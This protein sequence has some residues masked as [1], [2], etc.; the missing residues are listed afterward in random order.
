MTRSDFF[1]L[2]ISGDA[3]QRGQQYGEQACELIH[4]TFEIYA[5]LLA[6]R[7]TALQPLAE[8]YGR[9]IAAFSP[10]LYAEIDAIA[11]A[12]G[13]APWQIVALNA[14]TEI[15]NI[16]APECTLLALPGQRRLAQ[17]WDWIRPLESR[18]IELTVVY[19]DGL[20]IVMLLEP[21]QIGKIGMNNAGLGVGLNILFCPLTTPGLPVHVLMRSMLECQSAAEAKTV[22]ETAPPGRASHLCA[23]D[24]HGDFWTMEFVDTRQQLVRLDEPP[25]AHSNHYRLFPNTL[26]GPAR[27]NS[28]LRQQRAE[29][30]LSAQCEAEA[31]L[32]DQNNGCDAIFAPYHDMPP[33]GECGTLFSV[34]MDLDQPE[35]RYRCRQQADTDWNRRTLEPYQ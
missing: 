23:G 18:V 19:P 14:R 2:R 8:T 33:V 26:E 11:A 13:L 21:G 16:E 20:E 29:Q 31:I 12:S 1:R 34:I 28:L 24:R 10:P 35:L 25:F 7:G 3:R 4:E 30:L 9:C 32:A 17:N 5:D 6:T 15:L 22:V 27:E